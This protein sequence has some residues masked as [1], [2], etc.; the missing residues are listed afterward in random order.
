MKS[1]RVLLLAVA[2]L[3]FAVLVF[4]VSLSDFFGWVAVDTERVYASVN[5]SDRVG[6]NVNGSALTFG[7]ILPGG[8][9]SRSV[10]FQN[11]YSFPVELR[12]SVE[13]D[14]AGLVQVGDGWE[15]PVG[16]GLDVQVGDGWEIPVGGGL[17]IPFSVYA[18]PGVRQGFSDGFVVFRILRQ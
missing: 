10:I 2:V 16:G 12:I 15:I 4:A 1:D 13:G 9:S 8:S 3:V 6:F 18:G 14:I 11:T 7:S 17:E 5:V